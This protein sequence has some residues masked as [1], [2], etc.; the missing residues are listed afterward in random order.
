MKRH[1]PGDLG[2][3]VGLDRVPEVKT[4]RRKLGR[5]AVTLAV[6]HAAGVSDRFFDY[7]VEPDD[8]GRFVTNPARQAADK[9]LH[10]GCANCV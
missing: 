3:I 8:P 10:S 7:Q 9:E 6:I 2:R 5:L 1:A 4:L